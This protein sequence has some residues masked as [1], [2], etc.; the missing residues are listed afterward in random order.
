MKTLTRL[1]EDCL[2]LRGVK[3]E[4]GS[5]VCWDVSQVTSKIGNIVLKRLIDNILWIF[6]LLR[7]NDN[8]ATAS[9][10]SIILLR[11]RLVLE[12]LL[13]VS[14]FKDAIGGNSHDN[15]VILHLI[16]CVLNI[17]ELLIWISFNAILF[18]HGFL[19]SNWDFLVTR[20][21]SIEVVLESLH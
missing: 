16:F 21:E 13:V 19:N 20:F 2:A 4:R 7:R 15:L 9:A 8:E 18:D 14:A 12:W 17:V 6:V 5:L 3:V 1:S 10:W 11:G